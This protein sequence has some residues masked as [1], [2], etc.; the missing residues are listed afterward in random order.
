VQTY[1][2]R[3]PGDRISSGQRFPL[4]S[5]SAGRLV[6]G[7]RDSSM[8][9]RPQKRPHILPSVRPMTTLFAQT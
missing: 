9:G 2:R 5:F 6:D 8:G 4:C 7:R 1:D 3:T